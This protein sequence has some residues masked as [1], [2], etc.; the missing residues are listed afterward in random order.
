MQND[1]Q[2]S[3]KIE[4]YIESI[5]GRRNA[6][7]HL[8]SCLFSLIAQEMQFKLATRLFSSSAVLTKTRF[9]NI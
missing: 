6:S 1:K 4:A 7:K 5:C 2:L 3:R 8:K 9:G